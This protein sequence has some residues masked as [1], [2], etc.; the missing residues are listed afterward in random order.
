MNLAS[1]MVS[2]VYV[3]SV[4]GKDSNGRL[5]YET[6]RAIKARVEQSRRLLRKANGDEVQGTHRIYSL[7]AIQV[8]DRVWL[9]GQNQAVVEGSRV[10]V[11]LTAS[12]NKSGSTLLY[13][14]DF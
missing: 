1:W 11:A 14:A 6:P 8:T 9:P 7:D 10:P 3:A 2:T 13:V 5:T 12:N 4:T